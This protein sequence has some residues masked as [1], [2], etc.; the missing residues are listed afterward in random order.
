M[1]SLFRCVPTSIRAGR[2]GVP[3]QFDLQGITG[4]AVLPASSDYNR[5]EL[6]DL[7]LAN[8]P[9]GPPAQQPG[10]LLAAGFWFADFARWVSVELQ[11]SRNQVGCWMRPFVRRLCRAGEGIA[12]RLSEA[13][14]WRQ[15]VTRAKWYDALFGGQA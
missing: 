9:L 5:L 12:C 13:R 8:L 1:L 6:V 15:R 14:C 3:T 4:V 10:A 2:P 7:W 11:S